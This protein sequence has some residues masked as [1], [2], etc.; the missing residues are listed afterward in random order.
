MLDYLRELDG[1]LSQQ[2][3]DIANSVASLKPC[4]EEQAKS[5]WSTT[6]KRAI[7]RRGKSADVGHISAL[8]ALR[9]NGP[10]GMNNLPN[11]PGVPEPTTPD[12]SAAPEGCRFQRQTSNTSDVLEVLKQA[13]LE[14]KL[15]SSFKA[16]SPTAVNLGRAGRRHLAP[17]VHGGRSPPPPKRPATN[18]G[19]K[20][21][22]AWSNEQHY[23]RQPSFPASEKNPHTPDTDSSNCPK[24]MLQEAVTVTR[25]LEDVIDRSSESAWRL[26]SAVE[27]STRER[28][29]STI[30]LSVELE[31]GSA[32]GPS[33]YVLMPDS[34][35][36]LAWD[37]ALLLV[38]IVTI[39]LIPVELVYLG[40]PCEGCAHDGS[41][42][43][44]RLR[45]GFLSA[46][47]VCWIIDIGL[48]FRTAFLSEGRV[49]REPRLIAIA[50]AKGWLA[51]DLLTAWPVALAPKGVPTVLRALKMARLVRLPD[52]LETLQ[53]E[54]RSALVLPVKILLI[55]SLGPH[56]IAALWRLAI[57]ADIQ[58]E[59]FV[60]A[61]ASAGLAPYLTWWDYY[62]EDV[63]WVMVT[64]ST[65]G[66]G[67]VIPHGR[68][69]RIFAM[70]TQVI[71]PWM[72]AAIVCLVTQ[73]AR[74]Y[75][76]DGGANSQIVGAT[77]IMQSRR[78]PVEL[79]R[80]VEHNLRSKLREDHQLV[81][82][83]NLLARLSTNVQ[84]E[85]TVA[86]LS[87]TVVLFPLF[88]GAAPAF[89]ADIAQAHSWVECAA[90][91]LVAEEGH[92]EEDLVFVVV[93]Q[94]FSMC[95]SAFN[96]DEIVVTP[97]SRLGAGA[98]F[99]EAC[100]FDPNSVRGSSLFARTNAELVVLQA[101]DYHRVINKY[102]VVSA[103]HAYIVQE[104]QAANLSLS[105]IA[106]QP[107]LD[108]P[109]V[110]KHSWSGLFT[111]RRRTALVDEIECDPV[112]V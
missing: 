25:S 68:S 87:E 70:F 109:S 44:A 1:R 45:S 49:V 90:G 22:A 112:V 7:L 23:A 29:C 47:D 67:D 100:L 14:G 3:E 65:C 80:R 60:S 62:L 9:R 11:I 96:S 97:K 37:I 61:S 66:Y 75:L 36:R 76:D 2:L 26:F 85:L 40:R 111:P 95:T 108:K 51:L 27:E 105:S 57:Q 43:G 42:S 34:I 48:N 94:L 5:H 77:R 6:T 53:R 41:D 98:W 50:Y 21:H 89:I 81:L 55:I 54:L 58:A 18:D 88:K 8:Q 93:G 63:Y 71:G 92:L 101:G 104:L 28:R 59:T 79:R 16:A 74:K 78:V 103:R 91:D 82:I 56:I 46:V 4:A 31:P 35:A 72:N 52:L 30:G 13:T 15:D 73:M 19:T 32:A 20:K 110:S 39:I 38:T 106:Y 24:A 102:P 83:P 64:V 86:L 17:G 69:G 107:P 12:A 10:Q 99:G 33:P 84:R